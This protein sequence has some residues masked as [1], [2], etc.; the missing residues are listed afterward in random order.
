MIDFVF[1]KKSNP[2]AVDA[3]SVLFHHLMQKALFIL[4]INV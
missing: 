3:L 2:A 1:G 4:V